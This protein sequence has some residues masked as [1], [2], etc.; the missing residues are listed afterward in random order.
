MPKIDLSRIKK[1][2]LSLTCIILAAAIAFF[3]Y[4]TVF[5]PLLG[6][7]KKLSGQIEQREKNIQK[8][9]IDPQALKKL[10]DE[11]NEIRTRVNYYKQG[12]QALTDVPQILKELN[13]I[14]ER[15]RI[16]FVS[17]NPLKREKTA[18]PGGKDYLLFSPIKIKLQCGYHQLG[19]F[20]NEIENAQ[21]LMKITKF[22]INAG[23]ANIWVH[24]A[25]LE[26]TSYS[27]VSN[28]L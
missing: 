25:E 23:R 1:E 9:K 17:V 7:I 8:A 22:K 24:Q 3:A 28:E 20:I 21:R 2:Q 10:E 26:I 11:A 13:E 4:T 19:I 16:K 14:A 5:S 15:L 27:L 6:K 18:L 12:L